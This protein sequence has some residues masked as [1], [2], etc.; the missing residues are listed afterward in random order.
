MGTLVGEISQSRISHLSTSKALLV[1]LFG[2]SDHH[3]AKYCSI[4]CH[5]I[6]DLKTC[7]ITQWYDLVCLYRLTPICCAY[8]DDFFSKSVQKISSLHF[9][10]FFLDYSLTL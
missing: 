9:Y 6:R 1:P 4:R 7:E 10:I 5:T 8:R 3:P 2:F